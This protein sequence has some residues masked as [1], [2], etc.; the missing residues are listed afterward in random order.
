MAEPMSR[1]RLLEGSIRWALR[2]TS[3]RRG[4][5]WPGLVLA[6]LVLWFAVYIFAVPPH[7]TGDQVFRFGLLSLIAAAVA[8]NIV[9]FVWSLLRTPYEQRDGLRVLIGEYETEASRR[10]D[11]RFTDHLRDQ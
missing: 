5:Y 9:L 11:R 8:V 1:D 4:G 10:K 2:K 3:E 7:P 6:G